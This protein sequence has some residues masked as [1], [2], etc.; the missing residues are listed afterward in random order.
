MAGYAPPNVNFTSPTEAAGKADASPYTAKFFATQVALNASLEKGL[1]EE[2]HNAANT[3][4]Q[5]KY[6]LGVNAQNEG[7]ALRA[8]G[9]KAN[10]EGLAESGVL[11]QRQGVT[12]TGATEKA[13]T[14][15]TNR[16]KAIESYQSGAATKE[17]N[18]SSGTGNNVASA[19]EAGKQ[20]AIEHPPAV[21]TP[22]APTKAP[23][24]T[25]LSQIQ[26]GR[27]LSTIRLS[28]NPTT[29]ARQEAAAR[30]VG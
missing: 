12:Q 11:A 13:H 25:P 4:A 1:A 29:R 22:T 19:E 21:P 7:R 14:L 10:A 8:G 15:S 5:Y 30:V 18:Y 24:G 23:G 17:L 26:P 16:Q 6:G 9:Q 3:E 2:A 27:Q 28:R 20:Y